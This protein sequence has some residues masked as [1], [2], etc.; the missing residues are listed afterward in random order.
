MWT[1]VLVMIY[2]NNP[3]VI[4]PYNEDTFMLSNCVDRAYQQIARLCK[5]LL[6]PQIGLRLKDL[7]YLDIALHCKKILDKFGPSFNV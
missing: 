5:F 7:S 3:G 6:S 2:K 1:V 4:F